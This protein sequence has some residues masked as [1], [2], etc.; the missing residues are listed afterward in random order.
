VVSELLNLCCVPRICGGTKQG[1]K[2]CGG[3]SSSQKKIGRERGRE[4]V[5]VRVRTQTILEILKKL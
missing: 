2:E 4:R 3:A 1:S 5:R